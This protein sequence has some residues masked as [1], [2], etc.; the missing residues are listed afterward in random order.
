MTITPGPAVEPVDDYIRLI[1]G[2]A[3]AGAWV[4]QSPPVAVQNRPYF[5]NT[6]NGHPGPA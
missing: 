6:V 5:V 2:K 1:D 4:Y 3:P